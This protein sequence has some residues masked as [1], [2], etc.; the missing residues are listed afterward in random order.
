M[1]AQWDAKWDAKRSVYQVGN[2][3][4]VPGYPN[5][6][7]PRSLAGLNGR[8]LLKDYRVATPAGWLPQRSCCA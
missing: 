4:R 3:S 2:I 7:N 1:N 8:R 6:S 5:E